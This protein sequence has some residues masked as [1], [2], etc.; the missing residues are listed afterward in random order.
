M[1]EIHTATNLRE[2][3][4]CKIANWRETPGLVHNQEVLRYVL[5]LDR[6]DIVY[7]YRV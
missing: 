1:E 5:F 6:A 7:R 4:N 3:V 2:I